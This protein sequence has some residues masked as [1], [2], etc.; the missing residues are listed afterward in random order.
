MRK[1]FLTRLVSPLDPLPPPISSSLNPF[2][3]RYIIL[4][5]DLI[6][7]LIIALTLAINIFMVATWRAD[8]DFSKWLP[9]VDP[10]YFLVL[11]VLGGV[12]IF[13]SLLVVTGHFLIDPPANFGQVPFSFFPSLT[14]YFRWACLKYDFL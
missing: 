7:T 4:N 14:Y 5:T 2:F 10:W 11:Y 13:L 6:Y 3:P 1:F 9:V 8:G 12:H